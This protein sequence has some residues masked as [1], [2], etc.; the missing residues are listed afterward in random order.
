MKRLI[1]LLIVVFA[2]TYVNAQ[3]SASFGAKS[4]YQEYDGGGT[5]GGDSINYASGTTTWYVDFEVNKDV[6]YTISHTIDGDTLTG[7]TG[8]VTIQ[9][10]GSYDDVVYSN[11]GSA[12][13]W[14][15]STA[16][17]AANV[18]LNT[19]T[20][21]TALATDYMTGVSDTVDTYIS[22]G[23]TT[24]VAARTNTITL[25]GVDYNFIRVLFTAASGGRVEIEKVGLKLTPVKL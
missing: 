3:K 1:I 11:I 21:V 8:D 20:E 2:F 10:Q 25:P 4:W 24:T 16:E 5:S 18:N 13:T 15:A 23:D 9:V 12:V 22:Y 17:Y 14:T 6:R 19:Y 7:C